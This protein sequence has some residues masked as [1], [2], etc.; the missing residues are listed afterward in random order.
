MEAWGGLVL[1]PW[2]LQASAQVALEALVFLA[3][4]LVYDVLVTYWN[5]L[6][7]LLVLVSWI[8]LELVLLLVMVDV[9]RGVV[10]DWLVLVSWIAKSRVA[11]RPF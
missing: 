9:H 4:S 10:G 2:L 1:G 8:G 6:V 7:G 3:F 11:V 5:M